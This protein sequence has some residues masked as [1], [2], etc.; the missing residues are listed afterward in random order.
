MALY[1]CGPP[2][3]NSEPKSDQEKNITQIPVE[4]HSTKYLTSTPQNYQGH[5]KQ[6]KSGHSQEETEKT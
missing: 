2:P 1:L 3:Q 6:G 5:Q 4:E